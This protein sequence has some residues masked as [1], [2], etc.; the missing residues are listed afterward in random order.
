MY[1]ESKRLDISFV[2]LYVLLGVLVSF[3]CAFELFSCLCGK[4]SWK[5]QVKFQVEKLF[6]RL[7][8]PSTIIRCR[9]SR[10]YSLSSSH[11]RYSWA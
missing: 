8:P 6:N 7:V 4:P 10:Y 2:G 9:R 5:N 1:V 11:M 3:S